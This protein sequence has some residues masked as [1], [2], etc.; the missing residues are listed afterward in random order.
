MEK[1]TA[2]EIEQKRAREK[3]MQEKSVKR[4]FT[5]SYT[6]LEPGR[7]CLNCGDVLPGSFFKFL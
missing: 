3:E 1:M 4:C 2:Q 6:H 5:V 7:T